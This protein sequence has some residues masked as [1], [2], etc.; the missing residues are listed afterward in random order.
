MKIKAKHYRD[1]VISKDQVARMSETVLK[2]YGWAQESRFSGLLTLEDQCHR[3]QNEFLAIHLQDICDGMEPELLER[4]MQNHTKADNLAG[5]ERISRVIEIEG[6]RYIQSGLNPRQMLGFLYAYLPPLVRRKVNLQ[7]T[8]R[9]DPAY[10]PPI[11]ALQKICGA[12]TC[13]DYQRVTVKEYIQLHR[14]YRQYT[15]S[16]CDSQVLARVLFE[17]PRNF[18][19]SVMLRMRDDR[20]IHVL[21]SFHNLSLEQVRKSKAA[22]HL[23]FQQEMGRWLKT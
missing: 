22:A 5:Y 19:R 14:S 6:L 11:V 23:I 18:R 1:L 10:E 4:K 13:E 7:L 9:A 15:I 17:G 12:E 2:L 20:I 8:S 3:E 21:D 16:R